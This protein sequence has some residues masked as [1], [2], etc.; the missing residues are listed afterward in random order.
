MSEEWE[1]VLQPYKIGN[2]EI[3]TTT[4]TMRGGRDM[5]R[6][7]VP[8]RPGQLT[9]D[10]GRKAFVFDLDVPIFSGME[11]VNYPDDYE[12]LLFLLSDDETG[13]A[14]EYIDGV[15]GAYDVRIS[16]WTVTDD[17]QERG[18]GRFSITIEENSTDPAAL[19]FTL[20][21]ESAASAGVA[22]AMAADVD[23]ELATLGV[24]DDG[25]DAA[26]ADAGVPRS[27]EENFWETGSFLESAVNDAFTAIKS[28]D[29]ASAA[30]STMVDGLT[31][32]I[33]SLLTLDVIEELEQW[34]V[35]TSLVRLSDSVSQALAV[36]N[37]ATVATKLH[38]TNGVVDVY[39][40]AAQLK[41]NSAAIL[42]LNDVP[43]PLVIP[44]RTTLRIPS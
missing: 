34:S 13:G 5:M 17:A 12:D 35:R 14:H 23:Q 21:E 40:L 1:T 7:A 27:G 2:V 15:L 16:E 36:S 38:T 8:H 41:V 25:M 39:T 3:P 19:R 42:S 28:A 26:F 6:G 29:T 32:R 22:G 4:R 30:A 18:G 9:A 37:L 10:M 44:A 24:D 31:A 11:G 20:Q 33:D 43:L